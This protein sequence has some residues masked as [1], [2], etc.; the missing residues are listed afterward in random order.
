MKVVWKRKAVA[1]AREIA[2]VYGKVKGEKDVNP[3]RTEQLVFISPSEREAAFAVADRL[4]S[5]EKVD[6]KKSRIRSCIEQIQR[7]ILLCLVGCWRALLPL[8]VKPPHR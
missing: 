6:L 4:A 5:G 2:G 8:T 1:I 3:T 7:R